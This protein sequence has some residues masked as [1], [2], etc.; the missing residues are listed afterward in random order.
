MSLVGASANP[1]IEGLGELPGRSNYFIGRDPQKWRTNLT[2]YS[3]VQYEGIY[4]GVDMVYYGKQRQL[5]Y[6][7]VVAPGADPHIIRLDFDGAEKIEIDEQGD[8]VL[9]LAGRQ[10]R[11]HRSDEPPSEPP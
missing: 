2:G 8:L 5:E 9:S 6:D 4:P 3:R 11:P 1:H 7:F 10:G